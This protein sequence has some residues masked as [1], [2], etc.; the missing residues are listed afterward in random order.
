VPFN[1]AVFA[2][3]STVYDPLTVQLT[4]PNVL[5]PLQVPEND[6]PLAVPVPSQVPLGSLVQVK[7]N[8]PAS[9]TSSYVP[10]YVHVAVAIAAEAVPL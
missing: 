8:F 2:A 3:V 10:E 9:A 4:L 7:L 5:E 1:F 6:P